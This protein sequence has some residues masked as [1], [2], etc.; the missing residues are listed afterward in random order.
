[1]NF[2][3]PPGADNPELAELRDAGGKRIVFHGVS[4]PVFSVLDTTDW[5]RR[6]DGNNADAVEGFVRFYQVPG[7]NHGAS[8]PTTTDFDFF[9]AL[10]DWVENGTAP[11][12]ITAAAMAENAE[13]TATGL[14]GV[15]RKLCPFPQVATYVEGDAASANSFACQ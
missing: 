10:V 15:T 3:T 7:M 5:Y 8:G 6:L 11:Q 2:V 13:A 4:D 9:T 1:M 14:E 12:A